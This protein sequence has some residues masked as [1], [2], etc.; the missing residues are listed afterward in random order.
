MDKEKDKQSE[1]FVSLS[2]ILYSLT[3]QSTSIVSCLVC[4]GL[5]LAAPRF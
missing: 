2:P 4:T 3:Q 5:V 1:S